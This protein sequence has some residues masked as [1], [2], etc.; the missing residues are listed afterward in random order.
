MN[1]FHFSNILRRSIFWLSVLCVAGSLCR[2]ADT[3]F[4]R[5]P[6]QTGPAWLRDG[7]IYEIF[8]R[9]FSKAGNLNAVTARLDELKNLG[10]NV[11]WLMPIHP[12]GTKFRKGEFGSPY[13]IRDYYAIN[14]DYGTLDDFKKLVSEAHKKDLKVIMDIVANHTAW[15]SVMMAHKEY[16][17]QDNTGKIIPPVPEWTD[18]AGLNYANAG[19]RSYMIAMLKYWVQ[20]CDVDGFRCDVAYMVPTD[21]WVQ[22]RA[23]LKQIKPDIML[24]AEASKPELMT[25]A[26]DADYSWPMLATL[27]NVL[28][29][30]APA[31]ELRRTWEEDLRQ[32]PKGTLHLRIS[33]NHDEARAVAR[34]GIRGALAASVLM[35][36]LDG[37]PLLYNGMEVGDA[38][39]SGDPALFDKMPINW[40]PKERPP[41]RNI[42]HDLIKLRKQSPAFTNTK[43]IWLKNTDDKNVVTFLRED[44]TEQFLIV[45]NFSNRPVS[46]SVEVP[47]AGEFQPLKIVGLSEPPV[48]DFPALHLGGFE[49]RIYRRAITR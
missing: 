2:A 31:S 48:S 21:F 18:V 8:P 1:R 36:T 22:A 12:I 16:Y 28:L 17:K 13:S 24:L 23:E 7:V 41:L 46:A 25:Q 30:G 29:R 5:E 4:S 35:F 44:E 47:N 42:Y 10:V 49:A 6:A 11:L 15:D 33:D 37:A 14:P 38:T 3:D 9:D 32:F 34:F 40:Q 39:E 45:V 43:V 19:L 27:N 20:E 26:F